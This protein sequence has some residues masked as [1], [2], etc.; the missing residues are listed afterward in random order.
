MNKL[1]FFGTSIAIIGQILL[2]FGFPLQSLIT[3]NFSNIILAYTNQ[4]DKNMVV[5]YIVFEIFV[6]YGIW[7]YS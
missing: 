4:Q 2:S 1:S 3:W 6:L 5:M 7:N